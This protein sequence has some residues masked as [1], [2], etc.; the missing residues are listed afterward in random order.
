MKA[1]A[2]ANNVTNQSK[3]FTDLKRLIEPFKIPGTDVSAMLECGRKDLEA[4]LEVNKASCQG[5]QTL[6]AE[7]TK[8]L[9]QPIQTIQEHTKQVT[10]PPLRQGRGK[11][12]HDAYHR[13][14]A[15]LQQLAH[16]V[17]KSQAQAMTQV[18]DRVMEHLR[19]LKQKIPPK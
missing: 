1:A 18:A 14:L 4:L 17:R 9:A 5:P 8:K 15:D 12:A 6:T 13:V 19:E 3:A 10:A 7:Q 16:I 11:M 2:K